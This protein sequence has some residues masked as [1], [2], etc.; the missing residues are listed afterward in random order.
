MYRCGASRSIYGSPQF[1]TG[2]AFT[3]VAVAGCGEGQGFEAYQ[4]SVDNDT[5]A[6]C[7][8]AFMVSQGRL[9]VTGTA[10]TPRSLADF[11]FN[12]ISLINDGNCELVG[13]TIRKTVAGDAWNAGMRSAE[14][15][16]GGAYA[17]VTVHPKQLAEDAMFGLN[18]TA[19]TPFWTDINYAIYFTNGLLQVYE[20]G[21]F[22][23][24][25]GTY[26]VGEVYTVSYD[27]YNLRYL[28]NGVPFYQRGEIN[29]KA[30]FF[31]SALYNAGGRL[32]GVRFGPQPKGRRAN[33]LD[34]STWVL[35]STGSQPGFSAVDQA[36]E[37]QIVFA[38]AP[39]NT[40]RMVWRGTS[41]DV[42]N[43]GNGAGDGGWITED[44][45]VDHTKL[46]RTSVWIRC[47]GTMD[48]EV[49]LGMA[50]LTV[51]AIGG[52]PDSNPLFVGRGRAGL[53]SGRWYL[54]VGFV[55]PSTY[56]GSQQA[57]GG[58]YDGTTGEKI[59]NGTDYRWPAGQP[60]SGMRTFQ[61]LASVGAVQDFFDPRVE[62]C[63][64]TEASISEL[65]R[66]TG[67]A[68]LGLGSAT[69]VLEQTAVNTG[70]LQVNYPAA[71][72]GG[73]QLV[74]S[75]IWSGEVITGGTQAGNLGLAIN[76][77]VY[78]SATASERMISIL[79]ASPQTTS[80]YKFSV[81]KKFDLAPNEAA[82][83]ISGALS[84]QGVTPGGPS[85]F[86][87]E[88]VLIVEVIKR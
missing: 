4:G 23:G 73:A 16:A 50:P 26:A 85:S 82:G 79:A 65:M 54:M 28:R 88:H 3:L 14:A 46:Y 33:L 36:A 42:P 34:A 1:R 49:Y 10:A 27:G 58:I 71:G 40:Q 7:D 59:G 6:W 60:K 62:L 47:G 43:P 38:T 11:S 53:V 75:Y 35:G 21:A 8:T 74:V 86:V 57:L 25:F 32:A 12:G 80:R 13:D 52:G 67:T 64:G 68:Q 2:A 24:S 55:L 66:I 44:F 56:S 41:A 29:N 84:F 20:E 15:F 87:N 77:N 17:S 5:G 63:D 45:N 76:K 19:L 31:D 81:T 72:P 51:S 30:L 70:S 18:D 69:E 22:K 61:F 9:I 83:F 78:L 48:G 39:D 37:S